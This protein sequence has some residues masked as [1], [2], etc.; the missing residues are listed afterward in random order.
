MRVVLVNLWHGGG[1]PDEV[2]AADHLRRELARA[3][4]RRGHEV[5]VVQEHPRRAELDDRGVRWI[6][7]PPGWVARAPRA[8]LA[9]AGR[10]DGIVKAPAPHLDAPVAAL[11]PEIIHSFDL[12]SYLH[13]WGLGRVARRA[14]A[15]LV[16]HFHG[17]APA[18]LA[19]LRAV[20]RRALAG[21]HRLLF[22]TAERGR[23]W[24]ES[25][26]LSDDRRIVEIFESSSVF[27]PDPRA[28]RLT[29]APALLHVGRL[30]PV[31]DP[32][33]TMLGFR[34][35]LRALPDAHL[36]LAW[37]GGALE[38]EVRRAAAGL[39]VT[40]HGRVPRA[41][42]EALYRG[43]DALV[44]ASLREVCGYAVLESLACGTPPVLTDIPPFRRLT[45]GGRVGALFRPGDPD[46]LADALVGLEAARRQGALC[47]AEVRAWFDRA[48]SFEVL[49]AEVE[50]V[51]QTC[52]QEM[53]STPA[54]RQG[55]D[56]QASS[57]A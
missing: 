32:L 13:L 28:P 44:Q 24:V 21:C 49:A 53:S 45:D 42:M 10:D 22:T 2:I 29:G 8:L 20:E 39:P 37:T 30:D 38:A 34:R 40:L 19:P 35:A 51:Y 5:A 41:N 18:R 9:A 3:L 43:A 36:H 6:F 52:R 25:G 12:A 56:S 54:G 26:A 1:E 7:A 33:T 55:P 46:A 11:R 50:R 57:S 23:Q 16:A 17:G 14:G 27:V 15:A 47:A 31:K 48:L 4:A